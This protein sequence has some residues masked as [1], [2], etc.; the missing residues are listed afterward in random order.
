ML[1]LANMYIVKLLV[2]IARLNFVEGYSTKLEIR[3]GYGL[4]YEHRRQLL[5]GLN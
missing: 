5:H 3:F 2:V 4:L 1:Q